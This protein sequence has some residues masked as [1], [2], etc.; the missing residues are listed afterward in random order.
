MKFYDEYDV[1]Y[2]SDRIH[3]SKKHMMKYAKFALRDTPIKLLD[4]GCGIGYY[5]KDALG[6]GLDARGIDISEEALN[7]PV[8]EVAGKIQFGSIID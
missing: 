8:P 1:G 7:Q 4:V 3:V 2:Y 6:E 5:I